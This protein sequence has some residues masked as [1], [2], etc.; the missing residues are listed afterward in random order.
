MKNGN[1]RKFLED[2]LSNEIIHGKQYDVRIS[3]DDG[4][5]NSYISIVVYVE[6]FRRSTPEIQGIALF[7]HSNSINKLENTWTFELGDICNPYAD[8]PEVPLKYSSYGKASDEA[9]TEASKYYSKLLKLIRKQTSNYKI[10]DS[11]SKQ[12]EREKLHIRLS[13]L[14]D[15]QKGK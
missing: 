14:D 6:D 4:G 13:E 8:N 10:E 7:R 3:I 1:V 2:I 5:E 9:E 15:S 11:K 12:E